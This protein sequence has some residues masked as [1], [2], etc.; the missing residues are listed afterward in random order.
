MPRYNSHNQVQPTKKGGRRP[1]EEEYDE[2]LSPDE[3]QKRQ[4]RR[5]RNKKAAALCR[6]RKLDQIDYLSQVN[7]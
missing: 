1:K 6:Q 5:E 3:A 4:K 2:Y 7:F